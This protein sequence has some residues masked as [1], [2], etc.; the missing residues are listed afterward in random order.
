MKTALILGAG[1]FVGTHLAKRLKEEGYRVT[2][3]DLKEPEFEPSA[4]DDFVIADLRILDNVKGLLIEKFDEV[5]QLAADM[6]GAGYVFTGENDAQVMYNS[7]Q[8]NLNVISEFSKLNYGTIFF[9]SSACVYPEHLQKDNKKPNCSENIVYPAKPD[10]EYGWEKLFSER[11]FEAFHRNERTDIRIARLHNVYGVLSAWKGGKEKAPAALCRKVAMA[12]EGGTIEI[13]GS[14]EQ[15]RSFLH[16]NDCIEG[17][18]KLMKSSFTQPIN[19][20]SEEM[21][22]INNL[23]K[24]IIEISG[25]KLSIKNVPGP[26]GVNGRNSDN[27]LVKQVLNWS[28][29]IDLNTGMKELYRWV[30]HQVSLHKM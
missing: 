4:A 21:I 5:Y 24:M 2:G 30:Q 20:G 22:S 18:R 23:A 17:I 13:W 3:A 16:I 29:T 8:I 1:G 9:A 19:I 14:G 26:I 12:P 27:T 28:P 11:L 25:K 7:A 10:S 15:T 6:G